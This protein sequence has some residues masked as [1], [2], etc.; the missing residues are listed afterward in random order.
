MSSFSQELARFVCAA[1]FED[2]PEAVVREAKRVILDSIG[3]ALLG[4]ICDRGKYAVELSRK[5][6]GVLESSVIGTPDKVSS[7]G[8]A[9]TNGELINALD[10]DAL[11]VPPGHYPPFVIPGP[12]A[13][14]ESTGSSG[15]DLILAISLA[16]EIACRVFRGL[17]PLKAVVE[18]DTGI[19]NAVTGQ[20]QFIFGGT[21]G[22]GK[23]LKLDEE[24]T[25]HALGIAGHFCP[26]PTFRKSQV[27]EPTSMTK[28]GAAGW[29]SMATVT[30]ALLAEMG[31]FGDT[32]VFDGEHGFWRMYA[33]GKWEPDKVMDKIGETWLFLG[34]EYK[35]YPCVR[36][37]HGPLDSLINLV[38]K[39]ALAPEDIETVKVLGNPWL[40]RSPVSKQLLN[41]IVAQFSV[42]YVIACAAHRIPVEDWQASDTMQNPKILEFMK[43]V[44]V[45]TP[46]DW[47]E[48]Y[49]KDI[50][51]RWGGGVEVVAIG[52]VFREDRMY[53]KGTPFTDVHTT[54]EEL[55]DK[56][57][58][59]ASRVLSA[60]KINAAV[61]YL[62][63]LETLENVRE[64]MK[65]VIP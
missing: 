23:I 64:L 59:S 45:D 48:R 47:N 50:N 61:G 38:D 40:A 31:Y 60:N 55:V 25:T 63:E 35:S 7:C 44:S 24:K 42:P 46:P 37:V 58:R 29:V 13:L 20:S 4:T 8:A 36:T 26:V 65:Q 5:L 53:A 34:I 28:Y 52:K 51:S 16:C 33:Y 18:P 56:F 62:L 21:V 30:A 19:V 32:T 49:E 2:L 6:G 14:A 12:L 9:F 11:E 43:K 54:D 39:N 10:Y 17:T 27:T 57:R 41:H 1:K 3:C 22:A 15:K